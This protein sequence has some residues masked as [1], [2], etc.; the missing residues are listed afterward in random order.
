ME[1]AE[2]SDDHCRSEDGGRGNVGGI[3]AGGGTGGKGREVGG[4]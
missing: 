2:D 3:F 1:E 4:G